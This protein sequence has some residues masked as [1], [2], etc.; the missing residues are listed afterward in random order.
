MKWTPIHEDILH[1]SVWDESKDV[2]LAW[3]TILLKTKPDGMCPIKTAKGL[4]ALARLTEDEAELAISVLC[5]PDPSDPT[6]EYEGRRIEKVAGGFRVLNWDKYKVDKK[7]VAE[8]E[9]HRKAQED[10]RRRK[11]AESNGE[12]I[13]A[14]SNDDTEQNTSWTGSPMP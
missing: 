2:K 6:Q 12:Y 14:E 5:E 11:K 8:R 1:S 10:Y 7:T 13:P 9:A 4:A 3:V